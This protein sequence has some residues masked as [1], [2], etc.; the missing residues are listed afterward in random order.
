VS[1]ALDQQIRFCTSSD[2]VR[3]AYATV[4]SGPPLVKAANWLSH[5]EFDSR[6]PVWRHW[7]RELSRYHT[8]VR[9]DERGCG[10]SDWAVEE[11]SLDAWVRD[12]EAV[13]DALELERFPLLGIS[14]GGPIA[15]AYTLRHPERVSRLILYGSYGRGQLHSGLSD[16]EREE[17]ELMLRLIRVGWGKH[18]P[19]FRQ[20]F[21]SLFLPDGT[22]EQVQWFNEL[23]RVSAS[24]ENAARM[25]AAFYSLDVRELAPQI[26][27]PTLVLHGRG[28][29]RIPFAEGRL[30]ASLIPG[31]RLVP[32][33]SRNHLIL[34]SEPAWR[35]FLREVWSFLG[36]PVEASG[37]SSTRRQQIEAL[38]DEALELAPGDRDELIA[39]KCEGDPGLQE[40]VEALLAAAE[41]TG[42]TAML[43]GAVVG[44]AAQPVSPPARTILQ[45]EIVEQLGGGG[46]GIVYKA[47]DRRLQ[48]CV[49]LKVLSPSLS[50]EPELKLRLL[51]EAKAI[52]SLD[53][54]NLC[55]I[56]EVAESEDGQLA[57]V[58]P[59]Y[60]GE[61]LKQKLAR[62]RLPL[63]EVLDY[64]LQITAGLAHA[65]A[66]GVV[67]R[68]IKPANVVVTV[69]G[70]V[71]VLDFGIA[72]LT[73]AGASLTRTGA[74]LGTVAYM[75]P[76][77]SRGE[78]V[79]PRSDL[80]S[81][82]VVLYEM[83]TG[84]P[85]FTADSLEVL[86]YA[87]QWR[88]P[89]SVA[90][91][92]PDV[93]P[94]LEALV[95]RLLEKEPAHR[96]D[97][98]LALAAALESLLS[99]VT[100]PPTQDDSQPTRQDRA[101]ARSRPRAHLVGRRVEL[102]GLGERFRAACRGVRQVAFV[103]GEPGVGKSSLIDMFLDQVQLPGQLRIGR[104]QCL[105]QRGPGE[106]YMP[107]LEALGRLCRE[108]SGAELIAV[109]ERYAPTWLA[110]MPSLLDATQLEAVQRRAF[111]ATR[112]RMLREMVEALDV[113][114][115]DRPLLIVLEDLHWSD[116]S[117]LDLLAA[118]AHRPEPA[119]LLVL[120][121]YRPGGGADGVVGLVRTLRTQ[122][123]ADELALDVWTETDTRAYLA[124][125]CGPGLLPPGVAD[126]VIRRTRGHPL[127]VRS[128][129]DEW[130][131]SGALLRDGAKWRLGLDI[132]LL[133]RTS[134]GP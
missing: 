70:L 25:C 6:S 82:G 26:R 7:I 11:F 73:D 68:D 94:E 91:L 77:Q 87:I 74:V 78:P 129:L 102:R 10:L 131:E 45:Y 83:L 66:A 12:L 85:P 80:W 104:G 99:R 59:F 54:P 29:L 5:L 46:M 106:P 65:H 15:I 18:H 69:G 9:Y 114:T 24:P 81:L 67:H 49:A 116:P 47:R 38:F 3:I 118:L 20:V 126:L 79:D 120:G 95:H 57:L 92:R 117:T 110:Q 134:P 43:A 14:Q 51:Q 19:G 56:F 33:E 101:P 64:A 96:H 62:G 111:A 48:R 17:R 115:L 28:D 37:G 86:F 93:P 41:R 108:P 112:D 31:A 52:A 58:M 98:A 119:R 53:H 128:L 109:L 36:V 130:Q 127:L 16:E 100:S 8:L 21:T 63:V 2:G 44:P 97:G 55:T 105:E 30:L 27:S 125:R 39:R 113:F 75:S 103:S 1:P 122:G 13:V 22:P 88:D 50:A 34:E 76:E 89:D 32:I 132:E 124:A 23:Q 107:V 84:R 71:K 90:A 35:R 4:G 61:T 121:T 72:K 133:A 42:V 123:R 60:E 40:E